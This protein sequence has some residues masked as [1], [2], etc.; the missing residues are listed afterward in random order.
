MARA[1]LRHTVRDRAGNVIQNAL[2]R[3]Y[4]HGTET[5]VSDMFAAS[6]GGVAITTLTSN[7]Q[8]E[9]EAWFTT[10]KYVDIK[11]TD[12]TDA[13][14][15]PSDPA[16]LK[17]F[18]DVTETVEVFPPPQDVVTVLNEKA[19]VMDSR[20]GAVGDG[21]TDDTAE[22]Q[23]AVDA[24]V[25]AGGGTVLFPDGAF[26]LTALDLDAAG[27]VVLKGVGGPEQTTAS[28]ITFAGTG[29]G[30]FISG[31]DCLG[32]TVEGL[33]IAYSSNLFTGRLFDMRGDS[34][35]TKHLKF[36]NCVLE[37]T[38]SAR[39]ATLVDIDGAHS[40]LFEN[41]RFINANIAVAGQ[42]PAGEGYCNAIRFDRC[43]FA[44]QTTTHIKNLGNGWSFDGCTVQELAGGAAGF[45]RSHDASADS[46]GVS[47]SG[48]WMGDVT[49]GTNAQI[50][51]NGSGWAITGNRIG[52]GA[53]E[54]IQLV[55]DNTRGLFTAG[56]YISGD[57]SGTPIAIDYAAT[58][59]HASHV[60]L[61]NRFA[62]INAEYGG[63][64][65]TGTIRHASGAI[66][67]DGPVTLAGRLNALTSTTS[68]SSIRIPHGAAPS[69]P[70][71]GDIWTTTAGL[72]VRINGATVGPLS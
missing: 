6:S 60:H 12:N 38:S 72:Y 20:F 52:F 17:T 18:S 40:V 19:N 45:M 68:S 30:S 2:C 56:N 8:G 34:G 61:A 64:I 39:T 23:S 62:G 25:A 49:S 51:V 27:G 65:P 44:L 55:R 35:G 71:D 59:G 63:T 7:G 29:A 69:S 9:I 26:L 46:I 48:C 42:D 58:T 10:G 28:N 43:Y 14:Y 50:E 13:A 67:L 66:N 47:I 53:G 70:V 33:R 21:A 11:V 54:G 41:T 16:T 15:Y 4:L 32:V 1:H 5:A 36:E 3:V 57:G 37:G 31:R 22:V 24:A